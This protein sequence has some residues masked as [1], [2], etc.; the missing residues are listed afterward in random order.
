MVN[1]HNERWKDVGFQ[2][3]NPRTDFRGGGILALHSFYFIAAY[4]P[5]FLNEIKQFSLKPENDGIGAFFPAITSINVTHRLLC[6]FYLN[7]GEVNPPPPGYEKLRA[8]RI[9]F[10]KYCSLNDMDMSTFFHINLLCV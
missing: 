5:E 3:K 4:A 8:K 10:K 1:L 9:Q 7:E 6:Y 2:Q